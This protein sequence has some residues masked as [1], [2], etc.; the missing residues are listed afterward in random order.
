[1]LIKRLALSRRTLLR[2]VG[3]TVALPF[4]DAM[5]PA[6]ARGA[7]IS[8]PRFGA[9]YFPNGAIMQQFTPKTF[10]T[11]FEFT[12][13]LKPFEPFRQQLAVVTNLTRSHP[14]SQVGDHAVS[15]AGFLTGVWPKRTE[16]EDRLRRYHRAAAHITTDAFAGLFPQE[17]VGPLI[18]FINSSRPLIASLGPIG[19]PSGPSFRRPRLLD[20]N[21]ATGAGVQANEK[22]ELVSQ[23][24]TITSDNVD[25]STVGGYA[26]VARQVMDYGVTSMDTIINQL[27]ARY[28]YATER[29]ALAEL[30]LSTGHVPLA[31][32]AAGDVLIKAIYDAAA[33]VFN[34]TGQ[35]PTTLAAG[36]LG[37]ARLGSIVDAAGRQMFPFLAPGNAAGQQSADSFAGNPVGLRLVVTPAMTDDSFWVLNASCLEVYEQIVGQLSVT[38]PSVVGIQVAYAG[39]VGLY[40]P[41][42]NGAVHLSP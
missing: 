3:A 31:A 27:A 12:P 40:R 4:L 25:L 34:T 13:I 15:A 22:D 17:I 2:G 30:Q 5:V 18:N 42:P 29:L 21:I 36:P 35:L 39:Y 10:G 16:A 38:E 33:A 14:G 9:V 8:K 28:S 19:V 32:G 23:P 24:F 26:N 7:T 41:A 6:L 37:W 11:G 20:P 1:M